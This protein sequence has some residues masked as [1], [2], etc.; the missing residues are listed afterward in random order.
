MKVKLSFDCNKNE[1]HEGAHKSSNSATEF[2]NKE[3][4]I[5]QYL[6]Y[7]KHVFVNRLLIKYIYHHIAKSHKF[8][9]LGVELEFFSSD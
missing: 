8:T 2:C 5:C 4:K 1:F 6:L 3:T 7:L 9:E